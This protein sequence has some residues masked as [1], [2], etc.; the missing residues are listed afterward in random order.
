MVTAPHQA[1]IGCKLELRERIKGER[2][3]R[4]KGIS[5]EGGSHQLRKILR[6]RIQVCAMISQHL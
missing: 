5:R 4:A 1:V 6:K 3:E 2:R